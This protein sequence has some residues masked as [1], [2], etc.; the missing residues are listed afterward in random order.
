M[1]LADEK[2]PAALPPVTLSVVVPCYNEER[3]LE[4]CLDSVLAI[5]DEGLK[6]QM[7]VVDDC[8]KDDS[9]NVARRLKERI[10]GMVLLH[11]EKNQGKGAALRTGIQ[12]AT[13]EFLAIQ[14]ADR[15]YDPMD[16]KRLLVPLRLGEAD[17]V[18]GSRFLSSGYHRV[19]YYWHSLG[20]K[21]LTT[22]SNMLTD[23][24]LTDME[25]CY[26]VFRREII[27]SIPIEENRFGFEPEVVAKIAQKRLRI[28]EMGISY[29]G[30]TYA[31]GKKIGMRDG[32]RALYCIMKYNLPQVPIAIQFLFY[33][34]IGGFSAIV[35]LALFLLAISAGVD[36]SI[37]A[38][39]A[40]FIA[41]IVNYYLS[42]L[43]IFRHKAK[44]KTGTEILVFFLVVATVGVIDM[45]CTKAFV[46]AGMPAWLAKTVSTAIGLVLNFTGRRFIVFPEKTR[47]DWKPQNPH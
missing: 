17:V 23:L 30:R 13:G 27:Q 15:E 5:Q 31:E 2:K 45:Y 25:T 20:N 7:I 36:L 41:A 29:R 40:F 26:K 33:L 44:W 9:L 35:N 42:I 39:S 24:N 18:L 28:Y 11:H 37:A 43:L 8:S 10:P 3:T 21:F 6:L 22:L 46:A 1:M 16:L 19:L 12:A 32:W 47:P 38:L 14:D 34:F 4:G